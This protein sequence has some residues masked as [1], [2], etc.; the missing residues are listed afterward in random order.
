MRC[1]DCASPTTF[2]VIG[3]CDTCGG[4]V[5]R[6]RQPAAE[7]VKEAFVLL[8]EGSVVA[9]YQISDQLAFYQALDTIRKARD[10]LRA[11][12]EKPAP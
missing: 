6:G 10:L 11:H 3:T 2:S 5:T 1:E 9:A 4:D 7:S 12:A 8:D